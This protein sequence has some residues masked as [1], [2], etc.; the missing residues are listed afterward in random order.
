MI[1]IGSGVLYFKPEATSANNSSVANVQPSGSKSPLGL[2]DQPKI[3]APM[4]WPG[5]GRSAYGVQGNGV[6]AA[7]QNEEQPVPIASLAK[8][9]TALAILEK[10]PLG[11]GQ[12]GPLITITE[13]DVASYNEYLSRNGAVVP[14]EAGEQISQYQAMQA[15]LMSSANNMSDTLVQWAFGSVEEYSAYAN[16]MVRDLGLSKTTVADASGFSP[17][18]TSTAHDMVQLGILYMQNPVLKEIAMQP[19]ATIPVAGLI[20]NYNSAMNRE[21]LI[22]IKVGNTDEAG[23]CFMLADIRNAGSREII[24]VTVVLGAPHI[25]NAMQDA[26]KVISAGNSGYD[27]LN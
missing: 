16:K 23:R 19:E 20:P 14:V 11:T 26:Q 5:Y 24:S 1:A 17:Q 4:P 13:K 12:Q 21:G 18:T 10:K 25:Q 22:G 15:M 7:S 2:A 6:L 27:Q 9:I 8:V 3:T